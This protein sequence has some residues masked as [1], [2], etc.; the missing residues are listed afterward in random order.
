MIN[1][2]PPK[3]GPTQDTKD[4][5]YMSYFEFRDGRF[6]DRYISENGW[7]LTATYFNTPEFAL[8]AFERNGQTHLPVSDEEVIDRLRIEE[9]WRGIIRTHLT[10]NNS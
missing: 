9:R 2:N 8:E 4:K 10:D 1:P 7:K 6:Y 5:W 3:Q